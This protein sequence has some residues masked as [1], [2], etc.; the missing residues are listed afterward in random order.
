MTSPVGLV[1]SRYDPNPL[2]VLDDR[3]MANP[4]PLHARDRFF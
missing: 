4:Q 2:A 3:E 1:V